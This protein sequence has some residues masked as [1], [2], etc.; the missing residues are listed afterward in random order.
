MRKQGKTFVMTEL[1]KAM[2][3]GDESQVRLVYLHY[4]QSVLQALQLYQQD[5][6]ALDA[7]LDLRLL[8][9]R[10]E[11]LNKRTEQFIAVV[12]VISMKQVQDLFVASRTILG[13][14]SQLCPTC[15]EEMKRLTLSTFQRMRERG[16]GQ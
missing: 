7:D 8:R 14:V 13:D 4:Q 5:R 3:S 10:V 1:E 9:K 16:E 11:Q 12:A 15:R 6:C 2:A